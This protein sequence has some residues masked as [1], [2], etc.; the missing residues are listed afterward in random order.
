MSELIAAPADPQY[1]VEDPEHVI[2]VVSQP[3]VV[4]TEQEVAFSTAAAVPLPRTKPTR[5]VVA[6]LRAMFLS[7]SGE[8]T[9]GT[10]SLSTAPRR[11]SRG[12]RHGTRNA[13]AVTGFL[14]PFTVVLLALTAPGEDHHQRD[15]N[16]GLIR[17]FMTGH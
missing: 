8:C 4:I 7:S 15:L 17:C 13:Q 14:T 11:H 6:A 2:E 16:W 12:R 10:A 1:V 5:R 3:L 9:A